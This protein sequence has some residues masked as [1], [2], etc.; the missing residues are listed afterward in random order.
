M[1]SITGGDRHQFW[2]QTHH[3]VVILGPAGLAAGPSYCTKAREDGKGER[4]AYGAARKCWKGSLWLDV[5]DIYSSIGKKIEMFSK[6]D[7]EVLGKRSKCFS[8]LG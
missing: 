4:A 3:L 6:E 1:P 7:R 8:L 2:H 5:I